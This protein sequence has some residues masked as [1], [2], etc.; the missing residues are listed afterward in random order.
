MAVSIASFHLQELRNDGAVGE[1]LDLLVEELQL[2]ATRQRQGDRL[3]RFRKRPFEAALV[4]DAASVSDEEAI[5]R[6]IFSSQDLLVEL[7]YLRSNQGA[8]FIECSHAI[9]V[10]HLHHLL[11]AKRKPLRC[12]QLRQ[13]LRHDEIEA[14]L[15]E[16]TPH[17]IALFAPLAFALD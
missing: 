4:H 14:A 10:E 16:M 5:K 8:G 12:R 15:I 6:R 2:A 7:E 1:Q 13:Q 11:K 9:L 17:P 3:L